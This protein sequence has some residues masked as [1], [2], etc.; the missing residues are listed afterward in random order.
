MQSGSFLCR[1]PTISEFQR[2]FFLLIILLLS[3]L[4]VAQ[5]DSVAKRGT[6]KVSKPKDSTYV[7]A[8]MEFYKFSP[9]NTTESIKKTTYADFVADVKRTGKNRK[10]VLV[11]HPKS[12]EKNALFDYTGYFSKNKNTQNVNLGESQTD[13]VRLLVYVDKKGVLRFTDLSPIQKKGNYIVVFDNASQSYKVD[14]V[15]YKVINAFTELTKIKWEPAYI[16]EPEKDQFKKVTV[17]KPKKTKV[18]ATGLLTV[19]FSK[20]PIEQN[21]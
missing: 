13:T 4:S 5:T 2:L 6:I 3:H 12:K 9:E 20:S 15:H 1:Y 21:Y 11:P 10:A 17:I 16:L 14:L 7:K 18:N 8:T 19:I